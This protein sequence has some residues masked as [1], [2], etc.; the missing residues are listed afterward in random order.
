[1]LDPSA[2][3]KPIHAQTIVIIQPI[4]ILADGRQNMCD[5]CPDMT[6]HNGEIVWS[7]RLEECL[8]YGQFVHSVPKDQSDRATGPKLTKGKKNG[9][10]PNA[11]TIAAG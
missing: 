11:P 4:D 3:L 5:G 2:Y 6:V 9:K 1:M 8:H 7:C 10:R